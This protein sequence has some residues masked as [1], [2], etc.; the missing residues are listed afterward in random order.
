LRQSLEEGLRV[1][2]AT[3]FG[4]G[5]ERLPNTV[6][7]AIEGLDGETLIM[8][9]DRAGFALASGAACSSANP[10]PSH[11]LT[12]MGV[13]DGLARGAL[14]VSLGAGNTQEEV[15]AFLVALRDMMAKLQQLT[16]FAA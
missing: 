4:A 3:L 5:A 16:A 9:L 11:V 1:L 8:H 7:F 12:A 6:C 10:E 14:R 2:G 13:P 15:D